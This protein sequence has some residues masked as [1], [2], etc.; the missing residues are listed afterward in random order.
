MNVI[1]QTTRCS[2]IFTGRRYLQSYLF[3][4]ASMTLLQYFVVTER[5][6]ER[7]V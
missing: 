4:Y 5:H 2:K 1:I 3:L 6:T 7:E